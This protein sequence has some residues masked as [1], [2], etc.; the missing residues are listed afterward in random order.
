MNPDRSHE[1]DKLLERALER[2]SGQRTAL[3]D[4]ACAGDGKLRREVESLRL[5]NKREAFSV[6]LPWRVAPINKRI[7]HR[8]CWDRVWGTVKSYLVSAREGW[9]LSTRHAI[10]VV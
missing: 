8:V 1:I 2:Q 9:E 7:Y 6:L 5:T 4:K 10:P 3:L